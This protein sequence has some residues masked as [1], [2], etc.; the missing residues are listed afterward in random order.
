MMN[1]IKHIMDVTK[2]SKKELID[3]KSKDIIKIIENDNKTVLNI[4][5]DINHILLELDKNI[6]L[7][8]LL[9]Y[10]HDFEKQLKDLN[11]IINKYNSINEEN[12]LSEK[13]KT[14]YNKLSKNTKKT[15]ELSSDL[16]KVIEQRY[17]KLKKTRERIKPILNVT[18]NK[19]ENIKNI[20]VDAI[21]IIKRMNDE[22]SIYNQKLLEIKK[23]HKK[24]NKNEIKYSLYW[25]KDKL[26]SL[27]KEYTS[28]EKRNEF[29]KLKMRVSYESIDTNKLLKN[30][31]AIDTLFNLC[32]KELESF[33]GVETK[34][35]EKKEK[36]TVTKKDQYLISS[37][38]S[39]DIK[40][41]NIEIS[42]IRNL[43]NRVNGQLRDKALYNGIYT[44]VTSTSKL[45]FSMFPSVL[46]KN[47]NIGTL[48]S[49]ILVNN[50]I[51]LVRNLILEEKKEISYIEYVSIEKQIGTKINCL[52]LNKNIATNTTSELDKFMTEVNFKYNNYK[53]FEIT[54]LSNQVSILKGHIESLNEELDESIKIMKQ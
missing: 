53:E 9:L 16:K 35:H 2:S 42:K 28:L 15:K 38:I 45:S 25:L 49:S 23:Q 52:A 24:S 6:N 32:Q 37:S 3:F 19:I 41:A 39:E 4:K 21:S 18:K 30:S 33:N 11:N 27:K 8:I 50:R 17:N 29:K 51:K 20:K 54:E 43:V 14:T 22:I 26:I 40:N 7:D 36:Y 5:K 47:K 13:I 46:F 1:L 48:V 10:K 31:N 34:K 12:D 44:F